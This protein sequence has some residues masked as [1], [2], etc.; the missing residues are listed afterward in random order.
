MSV[1]LAE[2]FLLRIPLREWLY[3]HRV[4]G[5]PKHSIFKQNFIAH[6]NA[7]CQSLFSVAI[8]AIDRIKFL[9]IE[10]NRGFFLYI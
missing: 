4:R 10:N 7:H 6:K 9:A 8:M 2:L 1:R 5:N 3:P